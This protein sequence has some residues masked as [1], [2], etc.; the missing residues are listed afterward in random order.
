[1]VSPVLFGRYP[2]SSL[3]SVV[4][5]PPVPVPNKPS[6]FCG[7]KATWSRRKTL[8]YVHIYFSLQHVN[9]LQFPSLCHMTAVPLCLSHVKVVQ[10]LLSATYL[11]SV[12]SLSLPRIQV[13]WPLCLCHTSK[14]CSLLLSYLILWPYSLCSLLLSATYLSSVASA[15]YLSSAVFLSLPHI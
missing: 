7:R 6:R 5:F 10:S 8:I 13:L 12:T 1:M 15:T 2:R 9:V 3:H 14:V 11:S 4:L